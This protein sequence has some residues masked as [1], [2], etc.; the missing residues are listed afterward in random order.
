MYS[1]IIV[2]P[3]LTEKMAILE[4]RQNKFAFLVSSD[5]NKTEIKKAIEAKFDVKV[6]KVAT[7]NQIG[8]EKQ[9]TVRSGGRTIRTSGK[10]AGFKKAIITLQSG[11]TIDLMRGE[12]TS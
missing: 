9:M 10:R 11:S 5:S 6:T 4:E 12:A 3:I 2:K 7:M 8:K 1:K